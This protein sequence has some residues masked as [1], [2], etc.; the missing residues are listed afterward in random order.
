P[1]EPA[2]TDLPASVKEL[3]PPG[4]G[5]RCWVTALAW[6]APGRGRANVMAPTSVPGGSIANGKAGR[7]GRLGARADLV[8]IP[9]RAD[10]APGQWARRE[11]YALD[12]LSNADR[13]RERG[14]RPPASARLVAEDDEP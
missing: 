7:V 13:F 11:E 2:L 12:R 3:R 5:R 9:V 10:R 4:R 14:D 6:R 1:D 8:R